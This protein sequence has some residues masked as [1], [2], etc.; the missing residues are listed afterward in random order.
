ME[1]LGNC[2]KENLPKWKKI[3]EDK[4][5]VNIGNTDILPFPR[6]IENIIYEME[7][8]AGYKLGFPKNFLFRAVGYAM[9]YT[10]EFMGI[11]KAGNS[12]IYY[13]RSPI[14]AVISKKDMIHSGLHE[15]GHIVHF[16]M[17]KN[18]EGKE[19]TNM[20]NIPHYIVEGFAEY[21]A[22]DIMQNMNLKSNYNFLEDVLLNPSL[23]KFNRELAKKEISNI[24]D[25]K[26]YVL[27]FY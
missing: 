9:A 16:K 11:N 21:V 18:K 15:L 2:I 12:T 27:T 8:E 23:L 3:A 13:S 19:R 26:N 14:Y 24:Q 4:F 17:L 1:K 25:V 6:C 7:R 5:C 20:L 22:R 10:L